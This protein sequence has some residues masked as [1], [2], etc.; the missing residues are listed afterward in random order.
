MASKTLTEYERRRLENIKHNEEMMA[1]LK[2]HCRAQEMSSASKRNRVEAKRYKVT[3]SKKPK[4]E[5]PVELRRSLRTRRMPPDSS[6]AGG[7]QDDDLVV[8]PK[9]PAQSKPSP[10]VLGPLSMKDA[11]SGDSSDR[12]LIDTIVSMSEITPLSCLIKKEFFPIKEEHFPIKKELFPIKVESFPVTKELSPIKGD[13]NSTVAIK[14]SSENDRFSLSVKKDICSIKK[15]FA[16]DGSS[17][18]PTILE[19]T[20]VKREAEGDLGRTPLNDSM[21]GELDKS[22]TSYTTVTGISEIAP[23]SSLNLASLRLRPE[24]IARV[25]P[26]RILNVCFFPTTYRL[27]VVAGNKFGNV[28]FWDVDSPAAEGNGIY[29]YRPHSAPVSGILIQPYSLSKV[30]T[31]CYDGFIRLLDVEKESFDLVYSS[32]DPIFSLSQCPHDAKSL[33]FGEGQGGL[34]V[35]DERAGKSSSSWM[36]HEQRIN[37]IDFNPENNNLMATSSTDGT[38]CIWDVRSIN[39]NKPKSLKIVNHKRAVHSAY[40]SPSGNCLA[41][42]SVVDKVGVLSGVDFADVAMINHNN[43]TGR[44]I[45]SF[46]AIWGW[47]DSNLFIGNM[48]R[49]VDVISTTK[50]RTVMT[51]ESPNLTAI[52]CRFATHPF[53]VG[54]LAGAT[55]GGQVYIWTSN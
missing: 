51:L 20:H 38:A 13:R 18:G 6:S 17:D 4:P 46:R 26:G 32:K 9:S 21:K 45:S 25:V 53:K 37:S 40:F 30:F 47:D 29:L 42:T 33:Y 28:G 48:K 55:S 3:Q 35:W 7:V 52:P 14:D 5:S 49:G 12:K 50:R 27:L 41:T 43:Q 54:I 22:G 39:A 1:S 44:W 23:L 19:K 11:Y 15:E 24:Y 8:S 31:S 2:L 10:R 34:N 36:L 16:G